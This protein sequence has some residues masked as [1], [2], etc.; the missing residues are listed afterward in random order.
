MRLTPRDE[1]LP[2]KSSQSGLIG[3]LVGGLLGAALIVGIAFILWR[4]RLSQRPRVAQDVERET[5]ERG[6]MDRGC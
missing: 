2:N 3:G 4:T 1:S 6:P 5:E